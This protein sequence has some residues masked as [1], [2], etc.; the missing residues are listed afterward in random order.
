MTE[1]LLGFAWLTGVASTLAAPLTALMFLVYGLAIAVNLLRGRLHISCG[2]GLGNSSGDNQPLSW[3]L[4]FRNILL[5]VMAIVPMLP[6]TG[7]TLAPFDWFTLVLAL[8]AAA[9]LYFGGSQLL[10]NQS[11]I[12]SWRN[13]RA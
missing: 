3:L 11:A 8:L 7:R 6:A 2:C 5:M 13:P 1:I 10:Q 4:V 9:L 12:R